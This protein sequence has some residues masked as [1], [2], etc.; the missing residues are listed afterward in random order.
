MAMVVTSRDSAALLVARSWQMLPRQCS[1]LLGGAFRAAAAIGWGE[2]L[3]CSRIMHL[4]ACNMRPPCHG[5]PRCSRC[6]ACPAAVRAYCVLSL[7]ITAG[8]RSMSLPQL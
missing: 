2:E 3:W 6:Q 5:M 1:L 8:W 4:A 7:R